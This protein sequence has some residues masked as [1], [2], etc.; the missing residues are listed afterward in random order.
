MVAKKYFPSGGYACVRVLDTPR[1]CI[2]LHWLT[3]SWSV[4]GIVFLL[5][6]RGH[7]TVDV[8]IAYYVTTRV[9]W[10]YHTI[11]DNKSLKVSPYCIVSPP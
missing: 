1:R 5:F 2:F 4:A 3:L 9:F 11:T 8:I 7:Y 6:A 10:L